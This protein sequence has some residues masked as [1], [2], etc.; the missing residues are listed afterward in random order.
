MERTVTAVLITFDS[1]RYLQRCCQG[2]R[3]QTLAPVSIVVIDNASSDGSIALVGSLLPSVTV[4]RNDVNRGFSAAANQGIALSGSDYVLLVNPDVFLSPDY[5]EQAVK[6]LETA[7]PDFG[8]ATGKLL[9]GRG[10][11]IEPTGVID[12]KGIRMT[13]SGR[14]LDIESGESDDG[15]Q[16]AVKEVFGVSGAAA[17]YRTSFLNAAAVEGEIFDENFFAYREDAELSWRGQLTGWRCIYVSSAVAHHVRQVTPEVRSRLDPAINRHSVKN[18]FLL[19]LNNQSWFL[20]LRN[21]PF[22]VPRDVMV[23]LA[24]LT[25]ERSSLPAWRWLWFNR[26]AILKKRRAIQKR[27]TVRDQALSHWFQGF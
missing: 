19:R 13:R 8:S 18:R 5:L 10:D 17:V 12:S 23:L 4:V 24:T 16:E 6:A 14:H 2:I 3:D 9:R 27:R 26:H 20:A 21:L 7:G 22:E 1:E 15:R 25:W 11:D